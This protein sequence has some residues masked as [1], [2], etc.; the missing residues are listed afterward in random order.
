[1]MIALKKFPH[2]GYAL[3]VVLFHKLDV[4]EK[5]KGFL[6]VFSLAVAVFSKCCTCCLRGCLVM[7]CVF[8]SQWGFLFSHSSSVPLPP[9]EYP[10]RDLV[11]NKKSRGIKRA[12]FWDGV[13][14]H[15]AS[16]VL[17]VLRGPLWPRP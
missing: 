16:A 12:T 4:V 13:G 8:C 17:L 10:G 9:R 11:K 14:Y 2:N 5:K 7:M 3:M 6:L 15:I 1:M